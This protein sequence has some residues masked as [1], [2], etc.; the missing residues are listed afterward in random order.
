MPQ[1]RPLAV[2]LAVAATLVLAALP[3]AVFQRGWKWG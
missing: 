1:L 2:R 3:A